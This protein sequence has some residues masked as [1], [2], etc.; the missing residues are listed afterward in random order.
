MSNGRTGRLAGKRGSALTGFLLVS[1]GC[2]SVVYGRFCLSS[3]W[4]GGPS[5]AMPLAPGNS[6]YRLSKLQFSCTITTTWLSLFSPTELV[7]GTAGAMAVGAAGTL[8]AAIVAGAAGTAD[9]AGTAACGLPPYAARMGSKS[10][11]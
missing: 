9:A 2:G 10:A 4:V 1:F 8:V 5:S 6:P 3:C 11:S 7:T